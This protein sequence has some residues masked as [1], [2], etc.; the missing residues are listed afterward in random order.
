[1]IIF[2][3]LISHLHSNFQQQRSQTRYEVLFDGLQRVL[4]L[5]DVSTADGNSK[6]SHLIQPDLALE[7]VL[8]GIS[9]S[10]V[11]NQKKTEVAYI[12]INSAGLFSLQ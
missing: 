4:L 11:D 8:G 3:F 5:T 2:L 9:L 12:A 6:G 7:M 10:L 1:M